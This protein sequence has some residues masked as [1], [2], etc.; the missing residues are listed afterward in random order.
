MS[1]IQKFLMAVLPRAWAED[2]K[3]ES[4]HWILRCTCGHQRTTWEVGGIR[5]KAKGSPKRLLSCPK[6][7]QNTWHSLA[8]QE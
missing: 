7:G 4:E 3:N 6:C 1:S 8:Y 2:M 5:W